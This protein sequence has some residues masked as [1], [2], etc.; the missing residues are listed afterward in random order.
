MHSKEA[1]PTTIILTPKFQSKIYPH[2]TKN[3]TIMR[4]IFLKLQTSKDIASNTR[5][6]IQPSKNTSA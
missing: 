6:H 2:K 5:H 1:E 3:S 4:D